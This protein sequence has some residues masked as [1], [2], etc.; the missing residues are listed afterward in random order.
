MRIT[1]NCLPKTKS[2]SWD[3][4]YLTPKIC[5]FCFIFIMCVTMGWHAF[6]TEH[7]SLFSTVLVDDM[8]GVR[9]GTE[10]FQKNKLPHKY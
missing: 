5:C 8:K 10:T 1:L 3:K 7:L 6:S 4:V 2:L 9:W